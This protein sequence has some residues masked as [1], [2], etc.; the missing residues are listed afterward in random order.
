MAGAINELS[1]TLAD[2]AENLDQAE[3]A[4]GPGPAG[5]EVRANAAYLIG[6]IL[7]S[8]LD[9]AEDEA[10][11]TF[12]VDAMVDGAA[13]KSEVLLRGDVVL[14]ATVKATVDL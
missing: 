8:L 12:L 7:A 11:I 9:Q 6:E 4:T 2:L 10:E 3:L 14:T 13:D 1:G 5:R